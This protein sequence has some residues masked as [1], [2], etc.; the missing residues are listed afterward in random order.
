MTEFD[1]ISKRLGMKTSSSS[2]DQAKK[3]FHAWLQEHSDWLLVFDNVDDLDIV[4]P[5]WPTQVGGGGR[6]ITTSRDPGIGRRDSPLTESREV[7]CLSPQQGADLLLSQLSESDS[8]PNRRALALQISNRLGGLPLAIIH[9]ASFI[10][11]GSH[12]LSSFLRLYEEHSSMLINQR[13]SGANFAYKHELAT[14]W[15]LS[16]SSLPEDHIASDL[17]DLLSLFDPDQ[18]PIQ[19]IEHFDPPSNL[20]C[21]AV[22]DIKA[23]SQALPHLTRRSLIKK[24][25]GDTGHILTM[26]RLVQGAARRR[27]D[28]IQRGRVLDW[29][30][31]CIC[32]V[33]P[34]QDKGQSMTEFYPICAQY[35]QHL[36]SIEKFY[37]EHKGDLAPNGALGEIL[38][39][40]SWYLFERGQMDLALGV[41]STAEEICQSI[42]LGQY[43]QILGLIY[44]NLG[45]VYMIKRDNEKGLSYTQLAITH[46]EGS[47]SH[48]DPEIQQLSISYMNY[49][50]DMQT[51]DGFDRAKVISYY[52]KSLEIS[53]TC[54]GSTPEAKELILSNMAYAHWRFEM[55]DEAEQFVQRALSLHPACRHLT[56]YMLYTLYYSGNIQCALG[57]IREGYAIHRDC[58]EKR[59]KLLGEGHFATGVS[60]Y[61]TGC[62][63]YTLGNI[64]E[65]IKLLSEAETGFRNHRDD[66]GL[67]PM[68]SELS[69]TWLC[70]AGSQSRE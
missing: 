34:H 63:A 35:T 31:F 44:N 15:S 41:L 13:P 6:I 10:E 64:E 61:K 36:I 33:Y 26:H 27:W 24:T 54:P 57:N 45:A 12:S 5:Y 55:F 69:E 51:L 43:S 7:E 8:D 29:A 70:P 17:L 22:N 49:A 46:R 62:L 48:D 58:L 23:Q 47:I 20:V 14:C 40:C 1:N 21:N 53:E 60:Y 2:P 16:M 19:L 3:Y 39:H 37:R 38:A 28:A 52:K 56:S 42:S 32:R 59:R 9:M 11:D 30:V 65:S 25:K 68:A 66:P 67:W 4:R 50:N 18:I